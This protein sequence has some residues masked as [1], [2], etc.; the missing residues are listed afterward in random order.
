MIDFDALLTDEEKKAIAVLEAGG[1]VS[2]ADLRIR[3]CRDLSSGKRMRTFRMRGRYDLVIACKNLADRTVA[4][5]TEEADV[6]DSL[7]P[8]SEMTRE[9]LLKEALEYDEIVDA[10]KMKKAE[11]AEAVQAA[12][13]ARN[14]D[15]GD[16]E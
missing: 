10:G 15:N 8:I 4:D 7:K 5:P 13:D 3:D 14:D 12:R 11:L 16:A 6:E 9:E 1:F 2:L